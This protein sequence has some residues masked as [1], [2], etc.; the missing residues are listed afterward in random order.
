MNCSQAQS[1][2]DELL[3]PGDG[4]SSAEVLEHLAQCRVCSESYRSWLAI[5]EKLQNSPEY[6]APP[7]LEEKILR[8][9]T[10][11]KGRLLPWRER[12]N[13]FSFPLAWA[14]AFLVVV[15]GLF[16][17]IRMNHTNSV[18]L[19][20]SS[21][22]TASIVHFEL[23]AVNAKNVALVGDFNDW[24]TTRNFLKKRSND[25]WAVDIPINKGTYAYLFLIDG[26]EWRIDP[27]RKEMVPDG[28]GGFNSE[29]DI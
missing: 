6:T 28:F 12:V 21:Q 13:R 7:G 11:P 2:F 3:R 25:I 17:A 18:P 22:S 1:N 8:S 15:T 19:V 14:A 20:A 16:F 9:I 23:T 5:A 26:K 24:D 29:I 10:T 27:L 4:F